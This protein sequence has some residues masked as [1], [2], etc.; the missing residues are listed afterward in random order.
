MG[1]LLWKPSEERIKQANMTRFIDFVNKKH[2]LEINSYSQLYNWSVE[3]I[4]DFWAAMW[5]FGGVI[6]SRGYD[7]VVDD[8]SSFPGTKWFV[9]ARL[10]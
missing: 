4:A 2:G 9:G 1:K 10:N 5:E 7:K 8:L 3:N 6:V